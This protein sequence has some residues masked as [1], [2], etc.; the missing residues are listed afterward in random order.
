MI[1]VSDHNWIVN[2][3]QVIHWERVYHLMITFPLNSIYGPLIPCILIYS[4]NS[5]IQIPLI[6]VFNSF[7]CLMDR[8]IWSRMSLWLS[9]LSFFILCFTRGLSE[10]SVIPVVFWLKFLHYLKSTRSLSGFT[11]VNAAITKHI[12]MTDS[13][14]E[15]TASGGRSS[16][17]NFNARSHN[18]PGAESTR[19]SFFYTNTA[20]CSIL[21]FI[22]SLSHY[23]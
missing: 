14:V 20:L 19:V 7:N 15:G 22:A 6:S 5:I 18:T 13:F 12:L 4:F 16:Q 23:T 11:Y 1:R 17:E 8:F 21:T 9:I 2:I 3:H 10:K